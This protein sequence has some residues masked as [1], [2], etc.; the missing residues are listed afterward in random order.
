MRQLEQLQRNR[1]KTTQEYH[2]EDENLHAARSIPTRNPE[3]AVREDAPAGRSCRESVPLEDLVRAKY[4]R[5]VSAACCLLP[6]ADISTLLPRQ[7]GI[8]VVKENTTAQLKQRAPSLPTWDRYSTEVARCHLMHTLKQK[9]RV[10]KREKSSHT[11][12]S[13]H[14]EL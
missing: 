11:R 8:I 14:H 6:G 10:C 9:K 2:D 13:A 12:W 1:H 4:K 5:Q 3:A 7:L